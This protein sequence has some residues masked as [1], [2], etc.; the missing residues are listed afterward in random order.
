[1]AENKY[2]ANKGVERNKKPLKNIVY[3]VEITKLNKGGK[4]LTEED[5]LK[6]AKYKFKEE[7]YLCLYYW[8]GTFNR[9]TITN[10]HGFIT[11]EELKKIIGEKQWAK[12]CQ[13]KR[14]FVIQRRVDGKN[15]KKKKKDAN[16]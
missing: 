14:I 7:G 3:E 15:V 9:N 16:A 12:F 2:F 5:K 11:P 1:M 6:Y 8:Y 10:L 4:E 13:G